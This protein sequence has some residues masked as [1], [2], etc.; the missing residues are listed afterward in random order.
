MNRST[1]SLGLEN[2]GSDR[3]AAICGLY[4]GACT[5]YV[6]YV[7]ENFGEL[8]ELAETPLPVK[9]KV[10]AERLVCEGCYSSILMPWS[11]CEFRKCSLEKGVK[12]C[13]ECKEFPCERLYEFERQ[14][15]SH[16]LCHAPLVQN[17]REMRKIGVK[18]WLEEQ[19]RLWR[20]TRCAGRLHWLSKACPKCGEK[21]TE[22]QMASCL[23]VPKKPK[24]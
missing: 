1:D 16:L 13:F 15:E 14:K 9:F 5:L 19:E 11:D 21:L 22:D 17:L 6:A 12:Y 18:M 8:K 24:A 20:C 3:L 2:F 23:E 4:C 7:E 10:P